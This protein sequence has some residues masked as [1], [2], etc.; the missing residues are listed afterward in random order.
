MVFSLLPVTAFAETSYDYLAPVYVDGD[1]AKGIKEWKTESVEATPVTNDTTELSTGWYIVTGSDVKTTNLKVTGNANLILA[2]GSKLTAKGQSSK[3]GITVSGG[4]T[5]LTVYAQS[6]GDNMGTLIATGGDNAAGIGGGRGASGSNITVNGGNVTATGGDGDN[7]SA[8]IGGGEFDSGSNITI[9]GGTV[10]ATGRKGGAGIGGGEGGSGSNITVNGGTVTAISVVNGAGIGGGWRSSGSNI[11]INGGTVT[12]ISGDGGAG[13][14]CGADC[15]TPASNITIYANA[16]ITA[17]ESA[18]N[19]TETTVADYL[20]NRTKYIHIE[21]K[22]THS[23]T[24]SADGA[25]LTATCTADGCK[26]T[27]KKLTLTLT[28]DGFDAAAVKAW[29]DAGAAV[30]TL[31]YYAADDTEFKNPLDAPVKLGKYVAKA[32]VTYGDTPTTVTA[33][34]EFDYES[35]YWYLNDKGKKVEPETIPTIAENNTGDVTWSGVIF[36]PAGDPLK[37]D[38]T[39]NMTDDVTLILAD[40]ASLEITGG[41]TGDKNLTVYG[42]TNGTGKLTVTNSN[43]ASGL[44]G[45]LTAYAGELS[46]TGGSDKGAVYGSVS[47]KGDSVVYLTGGSG[48]NAI[49]GEG[50]VIN[51]TTLTS[52]DGSEYTEWDGETALDT[53]KYLKLTTAYDPWY[54]DAEGK[55]LHPDD[56]TT[57]KKFEDV[58][59][60]E[61]TGTI[62]VAGEQTRTGPINMTGAKLILADGAK[63]TVTGGITGSFTLYGQ[64]KNSGE[65]I[66]TGA[67]SETGA[68]G[69]AIDGSITVYGGQV[70]ATGGKGT[71]GG[72]ALKNGTAS[73]Y[74]APAGCESPNSTVT[75]IGGMNGD[76]TKRAKA[77]TGENTDVSAIVNVSADGSAWAEPEEKDKLNEFSFLKLEGRHEHKW[78][79]TVNGNQFS[80]TCKSLRGT[81][82][83]TTVNDALQIRLA[84]E[85]TYIVPGRFLGTELSNEDML[86]K[87]DIT[88]GAV[89]YKLKGAED[90]TA[91][92]EL[93]TEPGE[94]VATQELSAEGLEDPITLT[95][96][97]MLYVATVTR[98][99]EVMYFTDLQDAIDAAVDGDTVTVC[100]DITLKK[101]LLIPEKNITILGARQTP[102]G[103]ET[104]CAIYVQID[105]LEDYQINSEY[106]TAIVVDGT[107]WV[108]GV[109][110]A[111]LTFDVKNQNGKDSAEWLQYAI[112]L[113]R[114][115]GTVFDAVTVKN[116]E[117]A[118]ILINGALD[119]VPTLTSFKMSL[120]MIAPFSNKERACAIELK[121]TAELS[122]DSSMVLSIKNDTNSDDAPND[123]PLIRDRLS[124][125]G[126][127]NTFSNPDN[128]RFF[129]DQSSHEDSW[130]GETVFDSYDYYIVGDVGRRPKGIAV[131]SYYHRLNL[132][133]AEAQDG[134][135]L[136]ICR[137]IILETP[138]DRTIEID[139][140]ITLQTSD[141]PLFRP[142]VNEYYTFARASSSTNTGPIIKISGIPDGEYVYLKNLH[143]GAQNDPAVTGIQVTDSSKLMLVGTIKA[144]NPGEMTLV[145]LQNGGKLD[146][147]GA[148]IDNNDDSDTAKPTVIDVK[149]NGEITHN[150]NQHLFYKY[151]ETDNRNEYYVE[152]DAMVKPEAEGKFYSYDR[153]IFDAIEE[154]ENGDTVTF[155]RNASKTVIIDKPIDLGDKAITLDGAGRTLSLGT[156]FSGTAAITANKKVKVVDVTVNADGID[157][158]I[159]LNGAES[160]VEDVTVTG[161][162]TA[163]IKAQGEVTMSGNISNG[164]NRGVV[165]ELVGTDSTLDLSGAT[166]K[167]DDYD[168]GAP[169]AVKTQG[170]F[171]SV[172]ENPDQHLFYKKGTPDEYYLYG[173]ATLT[174]N[175]TTKYFRSIYDAMTPAE[176]GDTVKLMRTVKDKTVWLDQVLT[177]DDTI[178]LEGNGNTV[179]CDE[180]YTNEAAINITNTATVKALTVNA[181]G[182]A[183]CGINVGADGTELD[184]VSVTGAKTGIKV[185]ANVTVKNAINVGGNDVCGIALNA[186]EVT[187]SSA[188]FTNKDETESV[189]FLVHKSGTFAAETTFVKKIVDQSKGEYNYYLNLEPEAQINEG[190]KY[191]YLKDALAEASE[192][193]TVKLLKNATVKEQLIVDK[194][195]TLD[196]NGKTITASGVSDAAIKLTADATVKDITVTGADT[197]FEV[198]GTAT[199]TLAGTV[200]VGGNTNGGIKL[201]S[202]TTLVTTGATSRCTNETESAPFLVN[203][204]GTY[205]DAG[206]LVKKIVDENTN[207]YYLNLNAEAQINGVQKYLYLKDA[208]AEASEGNTVKL[209]KD[210]TIPLGSNALNVGT[211]VTLDFNGKTLTVADPSNV[212]TITNSGTIVVYQENVGLI[213]YLLWNVGGSYKVGSSSVSC[214]GYTAY[215]DVELT[216]SK[217]GGIQELVFNG[218][219]EIKNLKQNT[220]IEG[221][222]IELEGKV[223]AGSSVTCSNLKLIGDVTVG[224]ENKSAFIKAKVMNLNGHKLILASEAQNG[225]YIETMTDLTIE[226]DVVSTE[227]YIRVVKLAGADGWSIYQTHIHNFIYSAEGA[228]I[229]GTCYKANCPLGNQTII[230][231][232]VG[233]E[234]Y[235]YTGKPVSLSFDADQLA[236]WPNNVKDVPTIVY[237]VKNADG[238]YTKTTA[239]N[240]G[241]A[242]EGAAPVY[243]GSYAAKASVKNSSG[244]EVTA[245]KEFTVTKASLTVTAKNKTVTYGDAAANDGVEYSGFVNNET[246]AVLG[247]TLSYTY[248]NASDEAYTMTSPVGIY[249]IIPSGL[250]S[251]NYDIS[252]VN[253]KMTV[254]QKLLT[255]PT[256]VEKTYTYSKTEQTFELSSVDGNTMTVSGD[257]KTN[258]GTYTVSVTLKDPTNYAWS[259]TGDCAFTWV[260]NKAAQPD[261]TVNMSGY[262]YAGTA[263]TP[264]LSGEVNENAVVTYYYSKTNSTSGG[265]KWEG[266]GGKTLNA[267]K[268]YIY[269]VID[270]TTNY[271]SMTTDTTEFTVAK[272]T[273]E[274]TVNMSGYT[275][276]GTVSTPSLS[277]AMNESPTVTYYYSTSSTASGGTKWE[278]IG[279]KTLNAGKYYI[280][281]VIGETT[282]Y[283]SMTTDTTEFTVARADQPTVS[284]TKSGYT[285]GDTVSSHGLNTAMNETPT[286]TYYYSKTNAA[287]GGT[288]WKSITAMSLDA[289]TYYMYAVIAQTTNYNSVTTGTT[290]FTVAKATPVYTAPTPLTTVN[291]LT[292]NTPMVNAGSVTLGESKIEYKL[293]NGAWSESVPT[294]TVP[295]NYTVSWRLVE[296]T[297]YL[298]G[299]GGS[300]TVDVKHSFESVEKQS[301]TTT[302]EGHWAHQICTVC[303]KLFTAEDEDVYSTAYIDPA[304]IV[305]PKLAEDETDDVGMPVAGVVGM[306]EVESVSGTELTGYD[307]LTLVERPS[308]VKEDE[309]RIV[310][311]VN[312][313][314]AEMTYFD[315]SIVKYTFSPADLKTSSGIVKNAELNGIITVPIDFDTEHIN[316]IKV[317]RIH[318]GEL[319]ELPLNNANGEYFT[320]GD[321]KLYLH[322]KDFCTYAVACNRYEC[323]GTREIEVREGTFAVN[324]GKE[325]TFRKV[326]GGWTVAPK[327]GSPITGPAGNVWQYENGVFL[328]RVTE[329]I[330]RG[331]FLWNVL[332][333]RLKVSTTYYLSAN[334]GYS[335][336]QGKFVI[337]ESYLERYHDYTAYKPVDGSHHM[338][339]CSRCGERAVLEPREECTFKDGHCIYCGSQDPSIG[340]YIN[341]SV[342]YRSTG[343]LFWKLYT[344]DIKVS[345]DIVGIKSV[346]YSIGEKG[347]DYQTGTKAM[348]TKP[349]KTMIIVVEATDGV[350]AYKYNASTGTLSNYE[351]IK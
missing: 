272:A 169:P 155:C 262:T 283:K 49:V 338:I 286:V 79:Y 35:P 277:A 289:G 329:N 281:A 164:N 56:P 212:P 157:Y 28:E 243:V 121:D 156:N 135:D 81:C 78:E 146:L 191:L 53:Y 159:L 110:F 150:I 20:M 94:Y 221:T 162:R 24:Y 52:A 229:T 274:A 176:N 301:A 39:V 192:G 88:P 263:S 147:R 330:S 209:L 40:G 174:H 294:V 111:S 128:Y 25:V 211:G 33:S 73:V 308:N 42:Q 268:Y 108:G 99:E 69:A 75:L 202:G 247:G 50:T 317:L 84:I 325:Y 293:N 80:A 231:S 205:S 336:N 269:A 251:N 190:Q 204:G 4:G 259:T 349:I 230:L 136:W 109:T 22:H 100:Q 321:M 232:L 201:G 3:A 141:E 82:D 185:G 193:N 261:V 158:G 134:D 216:A 13:I 55:E 246:S 152:G 297:N 17:G 219:V 300:F 198:G 340:G 59:G 210:A 245:V 348:S 318:G 188:A 196:G 178:T 21:P 234:S 215:K 223:P 65:L 122:F 123:Y 199:L 144:Y 120:H 224:E 104:G 115:D 256:A 341:V 284:V 315:L 186:G 31:S 74:A 194:A 207:N 45:S 30:A 63:L 241:A 345:S 298:A 116:M 244:A 62:Y 170:E 140:A 322:V 92:D 26:L 60:T 95:K 248:K 280:Y 332:F 253:G 124:A 151:N 273:P 173:D 217:N 220:V 327:G 2:D 145:E 200:D 163:A 8:G 184:T 5:S 264:S 43:A 285:Y 44:T 127:K 77:F 103:T 168:R 72:A 239:E 276:D 291:C 90:E 16:A 260:I 323:V 296:S 255:K 350:H 343:F 68:G 67:D 233:D 10:T 70:T 278:G 119:D 267:G 189:P 126:K 58:E 180:N 1:P 172:T 305:I 149:R 242:S 148:T 279:G 23:F 206:S 167:C 113:D 76:G 64:T 307:S 46:I 48:A 179:R 97:F 312:D 238:N 34:L 54:Y 252:F 38:G 177:V 342:K 125:N 334:G 218:K 166:L 139:K 130:S 249:N 171:G 309:D 161:A 331:F 257:K 250:T 214:D 266:I 227:T 287:S 29:N 288:E 347:L 9:N 96:E 138:F 228:V 129:F 41:I 19:A 7:G 154:A 89:T 47:V 182:K 12:A 57:V 114:V 306:D 105:D 258:A 160:T 316:T 319:Q 351:L 18:G 303:G 320:V 302:A 11:T 324:G 117:S 314:I 6:I 275:Y 143:I 133:L 295:G 14:G 165:V 66:V 86:K 32:S 235:T 98:G 61:L 326:S 344:A 101:Q 225:G 183:N 311:A 85:G 335:T 181:G 27:D 339:Y 346:R 310:N 118:G 328:Q 102:M 240:S 175:G 254:V 226:T 71:V 106:T 36:V 313:K 236:A 222:D 187:N 87:A 292:V 197:G 137:D 37:I 270:E 265:T 93:P 304:Q 142:K 208:L 299:T 271:K 282:N 203:A 337:Y 195:I 290:E 333:G 153:S 15:M 91:T 213:P 237:Y 51:A 131:F 83:V 132:A 107:D 112:L